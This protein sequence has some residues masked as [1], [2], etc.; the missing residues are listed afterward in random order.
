MVSAESR[1]ASA[2]LVVEDCDEDFDTVREALLRAGLPAVLARALTGEEGLDMLHGLSHAERRPQLVLLDLNTPGCD[3]R[4]ALAEIKSDPALRS[5]PVVVLTTSSNPR[6]RE[7]C[8]RLGADAY[9][10]KPF[11]FPEHLALVERIFSRWLDGAAEQPPT[12]T[13]P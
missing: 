13:L 7:T 4:D 10:V 9:H 3:G 12:E 6:D 1:P 11:L 2:I 8:D 5:I